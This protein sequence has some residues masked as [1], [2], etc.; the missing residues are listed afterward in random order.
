MIWHYV[1]IFVLLFVFLGLLWAFFTSLLYVLP[2]RKGAVYVPSKPEA[3]DSMLTLLR[4]ALH[5]Q[6]KATMV[7][8]GSGDG[9]VVE[10]FCQAGYEGYGFEI[11]PLLVRKARQRLQKSGIDPQSII[12]ESYWDYDLGDFDVVVIYG[13][14]YIMDDLAQKLLTELKPGSLVLSNYFE[15]PGWKKQKTLNGIHLYRR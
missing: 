13:I 15:L 9:R 5:Q 1:I 6:Q 10:A 11:N 3:I 12:S 2:M 8:L 4:Q 14:T 7:D